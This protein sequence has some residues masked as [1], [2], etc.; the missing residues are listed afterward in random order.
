MAERRNAE[1][2]PAY[3]SLF[4]S[5]LSRPFNRFGEQPKEAIEDSRFGVGNNVALWLLNIGGHV[6]IAR[7]RGG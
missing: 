3:S 5:I 4:G 1:I 7:F 2:V 6:G